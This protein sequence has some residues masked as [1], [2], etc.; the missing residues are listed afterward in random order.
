MIFDGVETLHSNNKFGRGDMSMT[1]IA[2]MSTNPRPPKLAPSEQLVFSTVRIECEYVGGGKG[3]GTGFFF[4][5]AKKPTQC[6]PAIITNKHVVAGATRGSFMIHLRG[7]D[8]Q[9]AIDRSETYILDQ[10]QSRWVH[11]PDPNVDL[12]AMPIA[13]LL[14]DAERKGKLLGLI[15]LDSSL[16]PSEQQ[17]AELTALED[18]IMIGYPN[19]IWDSKNNMPIL[20]KGVTATHPA[21]DY[22]GRKE[23]MIDAACFPGSSGSPVFLFNTGGYASRRGGLT[24]GTRLMLLGILYAGPQHT[25]TGE[26]QIVTVPTKQEV[27]AFSRIPNNLGLVI[28]SNQ[29]LELDKLFCQTM[30]G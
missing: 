13:H 12:C 23:F 7:P 28:K 11:H 3:T 18:V 2:L 22:E 14:Q 5:F 25:V 8:G 19:G 20:R 9:P 30:G 17:T 26:L 6:V 15:Q 4:A 10:F 1:D 27:V 16:L 21:I 24:L 29:L